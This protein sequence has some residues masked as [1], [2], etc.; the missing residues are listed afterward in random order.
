MPATY[1]Y[2][3][4]YMYICTHTTYMYTCIIVNTMHISTRIYKTFLFCACTHCKRRAEVAYSDA[5]AAFV[6]VGGRRRLGAARQREAG[7]GQ[8]L[9]D[10]EDVAVVRGEVG[11]AEAGDLGE[12]VAVALAGGG[13]GGHQERAACPFA[14]D[15]GCQQAAEPEKDA[16]RSRHGGSRSGLKIRSCDIYAKI[17]E[18]YV[19]NKYYTHKT[20]THAYCTR[21]TCTCT[22]HN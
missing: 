9:T 13:G 22:T 14:P 20:H 10:R 7:G 2:T 4:M 18:Y 1:M 12:V 3:Y 8:V 21:R 17:T 5:G 16:S 11:A 19:I 15:Q 6:L